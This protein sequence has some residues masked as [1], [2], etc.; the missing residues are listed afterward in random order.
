MS[1]P[2]PRH[3]SLS[4]HLTFFFHVSPVPGQLAC[5]RLSSAAF[6]IVLDQSRAAAFFLAAFAGDF[7][8]VAVVF[9]FAVGIVP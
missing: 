3:P 4:S 6:L 9:F 1:R 5:A 2:L 8:L 7:F